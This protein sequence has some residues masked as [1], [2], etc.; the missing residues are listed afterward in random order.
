MGVMKNVFFLG[1]Q[2]R[3]W[4]FKKSVGG[5]IVCRNFLTRKEAE[6]YARSFVAK[7]ARKGAD[8]AFFDHAEREA[9]EKVKKLCAGHDPVEAVRWWKEHWR[10]EMDENVSVNEAWAEF[11]GWLKA[12]GRSDGHLKNVKATGAK[13]VAAFGD[14]KPSTLTGRELLEW[15]LG[16]PVSPKTKKNVRGDVS[17]FFVWCRNAKQWISE[18]PTLDARML[19]KVERA[20][21]EVWSAKEAERALRHIERNE[22][23]LVPYF[24]LRFFA[25]LRESEASKMRWEWIDFRKRTILVPGFHEGKRVCKTG[26]DWLILPEM[27]PDEAAT[28][29]AWLAPWKG[30]SGALD[31]PG[32]TAKERLHDALHA[33]AN[34]IRHTFCTMLA[35]WNRDD[36]KTIWTTR[37]TNV[38]TLRDHYKGVNQTRKDVERYFGLRP[39]GE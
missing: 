37:H 26:D 6:D 19:P 2:E 3:P 16:L 35:S 4:R 20:R 23:K 32:R 39:K 36:G 34:V 28:V 31:K 12:S 18:V 5:K 30:S 25:G 8:S 9:W 17:S 11:V 21:V 22:P 1:N 24:A 38:Q 33:P 29:F 14:R 27:L 15:V 13:F 10:P 7:V